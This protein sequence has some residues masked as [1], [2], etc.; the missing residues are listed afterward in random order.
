MPYTLSTPADNVNS[1]TPAASTEYL[2]IDPHR[3]SREPNPRPRISRAV[4]RIC[5]HL[6][7]PVAARGPARYPLATLLYE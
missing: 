1:A 2:V 4:N 7:I 3:V 6:R 5:G